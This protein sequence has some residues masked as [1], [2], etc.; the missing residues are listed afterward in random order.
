MRIRQVF[1]LSLLLGAVIG[2]L[3]T[4]LFAWQQLTSLQAARTAGSDAQLLAAM[5]RLPEKLNIERAW[6]NPRLASANP[7]TAEE[8]AALKKITGGSDEAFAKARSLAQLRDDLTALDPIEQKLKSLRGTA[9]DAVAQ[10]KASR[11]DV[12]MR[13]YVPQMFTVQEATGSHVEVIVRRINAA[14]PAVGQAARLAVIGWDLRDWAGRAT[15]TLIRMIATKQPMAGEPAEA[16]AAFKGRIDRIWATAKLAA[17][18]ID[19]KP[20]F[21]AIA[22][23]ENGYWARGGELYTS[24]VAPNRGKVLELDPDQFLR[25]LFPI[26]DTIL[27]L[28]DAALTEALRQSEAA[29]SEAQARFVLALVLLVVNIAAAALGTIWFNGR[30]IKP[31]STLTELIG[32]IAGGE[33]DVA[34]AYRDRTDEVGT[35]ANAI[36]VL[37]E[38]SAEA[39]RLSLQGA[40]AE[41]RRDAR[42]QKIEALTRRFGEVIDTLCGRLSDAAS[43]LKQSAETL[44]GSASTTASRATAVADA[45]AQ[46]TSGV[47]TVAAASEELDAS[48]KEITRQI[49]E[50]ASESS[51]ATSQA[52]DTTDKVRTLAGSAT[53]IGDVVQLIRAIASQTNLLALNATIESARAG[54]AG[55]GFAVVASE[56]KSLASQT[57]KATEEIESQ[58]AAIQNETGS[59]VAA[60][61]KIA[62][63]VNTISGVTGA[64]ASAVAEQSATTREI[65]RSVQQTASGTNDV[66]SSIALVSAAAADTRGSARSLLDSAASLAGQAT[67]LRREVDQFLAEV[68]AA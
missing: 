41:A 54:E 35:L 66:S 30:V 64:V 38:K 43:G 20:I 47:N 40:D 21:A 68:K 63:V 11:P 53:R 8:L 12:I 59:T 25:S 13:D 34:I 16:L 39:D 5:L 32:R 9:L 65:A 29:I 18:E 23:V 19:Q 52:L 60:I 7:A 44:D 50:A 28:R 22:E 61:E 27:P 3:A 37:Q 46:A 48:M 58:I 6:V 14:N 42:R 57:S 33:R 4:V 2:L 36:G 67:D 55:K 56:V 10:P 62:A 15:T 26:L 17:A 24:Q 31:L 1:L 51:N 49:A 45:A